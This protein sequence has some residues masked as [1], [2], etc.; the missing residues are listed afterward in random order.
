[1]KPKTPNLS[2]DGTVAKLITA[3]RRGDLTEDQTE[4]LAKSLQV[5]GCSPTELREL[6]GLSLAFYHKYRA[7]LPP[8]IKIGRRVIHPWRAMWAWEEEMLAK[9]GGQ[10]IDHGVLRD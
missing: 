10:E 4:S 1:M 8:F 2:L 3:I 5:G 7:Q 9:E 6:Y